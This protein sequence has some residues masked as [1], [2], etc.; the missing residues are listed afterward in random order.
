[1]LSPSITAGR[2][3]MITI[4]VDDPDPQ[5]AADLAN[6]YVE[7]LYKLA[8]WIDI[9]L[10]GSGVTC[11]PVERQVEADVKGRA[12]LFC[13]CHYS[14]KSIFSIKQFSRSGRSTARRQ[15]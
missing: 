9:A 14:G 1:M 2:D 12:C 13:E 3:G 7:E 6:A 11:L 4:E 8:Q 10:S 5:R 15:C